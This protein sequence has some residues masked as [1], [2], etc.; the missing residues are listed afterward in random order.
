MSSQVVHSHWITASCDEGSSGSADALFPYWSFTKTVIAICALKLSEDGALDLDAKIEGSNYTLRQLLAHT[1]GLPDY[2]QFPAYGEAVRANEEPWSRNK[3]LELAFSNGMLFE[4]TQGWSYSNIGYMFVRE[5]IEFRT[6]Q[7]LGDVISDMICEPLGLKSV[8]LAKSHEQFGRL[9]W[10]AAANY[11]P[12]WVYHG[13]LMGTAA[14]AARLLHGLFAGELLH[15][16][17]LSQMLKTKLLGGPLPGRP[18]TTCGY[19]LGLMSGTID[20]IGRSVG[21]SGGGPF[22]VN[23]VYHFPDANDPI[24]IAS[25]TDGTNEGIAE[26]ATTKLIV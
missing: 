5:L 14:D 2:G 20:G 1:S 26:I 22:C 7:T 19:A 21:H 15:P 10:A 17:T 11:D 16:D 12:R 18:W 24:T 6:E 25:F 4:P 23:A 3:M 8:E 13:C 9:H